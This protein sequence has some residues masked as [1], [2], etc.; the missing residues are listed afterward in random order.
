MT[1]FFSRRQFEELLSTA[2]EKK[3]VVSQGDNGVSCHSAVVKY[4]DKLYR[5]LYWH[6]IGRGIHEDEELLQGEEVKAI[7]KTITVYER[8]VD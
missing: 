4:Y 7:T 3:C 6:T 8:E 5:V 1:V 2:V